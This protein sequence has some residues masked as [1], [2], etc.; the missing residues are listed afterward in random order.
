MKCHLK[1][2]FQQR[3]LFHFEVLDST[4]Q[5]LSRY[6]EPVEVRLSCLLADAL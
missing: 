6:R 3:L 4:Q 5:M 1:F 2:V